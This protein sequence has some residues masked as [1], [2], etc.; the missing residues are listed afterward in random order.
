MVHVK[1]HGRTLTIEACPDKFQKSPTRLDELTQYLEILQLHTE[2]EWLSDEED[3]GDGHGVG[4]PPMQ[5]PVLDLSLDGCY[6]WA[7][8]PFL[9]LMEKLAPRPGDAAIITLQHFFSGESFEANLE[10]FDDTLLPGVIHAVDEMEDL[11][12]DAGI[13]WKT[14]CPIFQAR[15]VEVLSDDPTHILIDEPTRVRIQGK[16][17][18]F[19]AFMDPDDSIGAH[20]VQTL[21]K[22]LKAGFDPRKVRTSRLYGIVKDNKSHV[23]GLLLHNIQVDDTLFDKVI[24][25]KSLGTDVKDKWKKQV[26]GTVEALHG[27]GIIW[28]DAKAS[29]VLVDIAGDAW[30]VDFGGGHTEGWVDH[31][32]AGTIEGDLQGLRAIIDFI[33]MGREPE[34]TGAIR[35]LRI[36]VP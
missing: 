31:D 33:D 19:K 25:T 26:T 35:H 14:T 1:M 10:A 5:R 3:S 9:P 15:E 2:G 13:R 21:E 18:F 24:D 30:V 28:G 32:K 16:E 6:E 11:V 20:E 36:D 29:N 34:M 7:V 4:E 8:R 12:D 22:I 17:L 27:A 23:I